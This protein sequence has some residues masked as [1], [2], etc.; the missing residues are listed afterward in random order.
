M[1]CPRA[2]PSKSM[3]QY[4]AHGT[5]LGLPLL[6]A[7]VLRALC[8][9]ISSY[10]FAIYKLN[11][12][13][14]DASSSKA[15]RVR[16]ALILASIEFVEVGCWETGSFH[17][18]REVCITVVITE[19]GAAEWSAARGVGKVIG[20]S[21]GDGAAGDSCWKRSDCHTWVLRCEWAGGNETKRGEDGND[22]HC[23]V[24]DSL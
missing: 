10:S 12:Y 20:D 3:H 16:I 4:T 24:D 11:T 14:V 8:I 7:T 6:V 1:K 2:I 23:D 5:S 21:G 18:G 17:A 15:V 13:K 22:F 19:I 9:I